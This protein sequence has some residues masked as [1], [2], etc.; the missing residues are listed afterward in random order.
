M[1]CSLPPSSWTFAHLPATTRHTYSPYLRSR[2]RSHLH[3]HLFPLPSSSLT[4][5]LHQPRY[6]QRHYAFQSQSQNHA[7][8]GLSK[9][10]NVDK[11]IEDPHAALR[12]MRVFGKEKI[13]LVLDLLRAWEKAGLG[14]AGGWADLSVLLVWLWLLGWWIE[15]GTPHGV[16]RHGIDYRRNISIIA[17]ID[18]CI[19]SSLSPLSLYSTYSASSSI[20]VIVVSS[21]PMIYHVIMFIISKLDRQW[22]RDKTGSDL[23]VCISC[24][25]ST[26]E[27]NHITSCLI[28]MTS[29]TISSSL[30]NSYHTTAFLLSVNQ[31][32]PGQNLAINFSSP[33]FVERNFDV[34]HHVALTI[35]STQIA[36]KEYSSRPTTRGT[37]PFSTI[38]LPSLP[39]ISRSKLTSSSLW[40]DIVSLLSGLPPRR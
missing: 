37:S 12:D 3:L 26:I 14:W 9:I 15:F 6:I 35:S 21:Y 13:R 7:S 27:S 30:I 23:L 17:H 19:P 22:D 18:V 20:I 40:S 11:T 4:P 39:T 10:T 24:V 31:F 32:Y 33:I 1:S 16:W 38:T 8:P 36:W 28:G 25:L 2:S 29:R 5:H 34:H